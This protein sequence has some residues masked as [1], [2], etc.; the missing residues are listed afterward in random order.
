[1]IRTYPQYEENFGS[2]RAKSLD[3]STSSAIFGRSCGLSR[4]IPGVARFAGARFGWPCSAVM[5]HYLAWIS[6]ILLPTSEAIPAPA[7]G[8]D[9]FLDL[10]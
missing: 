3:S 9:V 1:M 6:S 4:E 5:N 7:S 10:L 2:G 8:L